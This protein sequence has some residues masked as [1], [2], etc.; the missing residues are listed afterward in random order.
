MK[1]LIADDS[2]SKTV[3]P[4]EISDTESVEEIPTKNVSTRDELLGTESEFIIMFLLHIIIHEEKINFRQS[5][6]AE[7]QRFRGCRRDIG[8]SSKYA[9]ENS[10]RYVD[11][12]KKSKRTI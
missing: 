5:T 1:S 9:R 2:G 3:S 11:F 7:Y 6:I 8:I 4:K 10:R 12:D